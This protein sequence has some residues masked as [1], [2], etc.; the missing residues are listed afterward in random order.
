[1]FDDKEKQL[2]ATGIILAVD[3]FRL[4][5]KNETQ[6]HDIVMQAAQLVEKLKINEEYSKAC[7]ATAGIGQIFRECREQIKN[8]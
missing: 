3:Y 4:F 7:A 8:L 2:L 6:K 5:A 1:M